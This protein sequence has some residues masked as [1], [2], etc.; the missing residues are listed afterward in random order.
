MWLLI[1]TAAGP[2]IVASIASSL[3]PLRSQMFCTAGLPVFGPEL[4]VLLSDLSLKG[5]DLLQISAAFDDVCPS[6]LRV[7]VIASFLSSHQNIDVPGARAGHNVDHSDTD[8]HLSSSL[9]R[10][11]RLP[12]ILLCIWSVASTN[13]PDTR[14]DLE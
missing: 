7:A 5:V 6:L 13:K 9:W 14:P 3:V 4:Y 11:N 2:I 12:L 1:V 8:V 10:K